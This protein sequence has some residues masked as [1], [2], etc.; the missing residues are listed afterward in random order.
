MTRPCKLSCINKFYIEKGIQVIITTHSPATIS[1]APDFA[2]FYEIFHQ[3]ND[4]PKIVE[5]NKYDYEELRESNKSFYLETIVRVQKRILKQIKKVHYLISC[6]INQNNVINYYI[7]KL[8]KIEGVEIES[9][10]N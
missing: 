5:V 8:K 3:D 1:L 6:D 2:H 4:S 9:T 7:E 10:T